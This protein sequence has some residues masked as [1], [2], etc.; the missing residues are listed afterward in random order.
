MIRFLERNGYDVS[1]TTDIDSDRRGDLIK[2]HHVFLSIGHDEYWSGNQRANVEP[3]RATPASTS[4]SSAATRSTGRPGWETSED[5]ANTPYRTARLLQGDL[6]ER[7]DRPD[8]L[9]VDRHLARPALQPAVQRRPAGERAD[10]HRRTC[11]TATTSPC[12]CPA[13]QGKYRFWRN[14]TVANTRR[15]TDGHAARRTRSATSPMRTSTTGSGRPGLIR[16]STTTGTTPEY[17]RDF[18]NTVTPGTTTHHMTLYKAASGALVFGAGTIQCAWGLDANHD[19]FATRPADSRMQQAT[20]NLLADMGAQ[21]GS[22][23]DRPAA[24]RRLDRHAPRRPRPSPRPP[25]APAWP[26]GRWSP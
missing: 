11:P 14:T 21:P 18:G 26:T 5:G 6:G 8:L 22:L 15:R 13:A 25:P 12:R 20:V 10:R 23:I 4:P 24:G 2:N 19:G 9:G 16:L 3:R 17:L 7:E 1:Y